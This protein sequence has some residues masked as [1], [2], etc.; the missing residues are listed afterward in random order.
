MKL[1]LRHKITGMACI[2]ALLPT[3]ALLLLAGIQRSGISSAVREDLDSV[4]Q[5]SIKQLTLD[6]YHSC[7]A[8][9]DF[10]R[11]E[12][13][14]NLN[15]AEKLLKAAGLVRLSAEKTE[16]HA[17]NQ[18]TE[19]VSTV[20]LP[21]MTLG[22]APLVQNAGAAVSVPVVDEV[23]GLV[24]GA[25]TIF[26]KMNEQ[27]DMLRI[28]TT[29]RTTGGTRATGTYIPA[30]HADGTP[31]PVISAIS[32]GE[33]FL[34]R[35]LVVHDWY[36]SAYKPIVNAERNPIGMLFVGIDQSRIAGL[37]SAITSVRAGKSGEVYVIR[38][39]NELRGRVIIPKEG[40]RE[41]DSLWETRDAEGKLFV[42]SIVTKALALAK[43]DVA[44]E[45]YLW[46]RDSNSAPKVVTAA[47]AYFQP[48][49]WIIIADAYEEEFHGARDKLESALG[50]LFWW[51]V[52]SGL[53]TMGIALIIAS[54]L[55]GKVTVP[56]G[57][58][59]SVAQ[60]IAQGDLRSARQSLFET[61]AAGDGNLPA[62]ADG[63]A[64][65]QDE[66]GQLIGAIQTMTGGLIS[67]VGQVKQSSIQLVSTSTEIA[68]AARQQEAT[69]SDL[70][71]STN[72]VV[73]ATRE[74]SATSQELLKTMNDVTQMAGATAS[75]AGS[76][77]SGLAGM[78]AN[79]RQLVDATRSIS[80]R[81]AVISDK[82]NNIN[83][84][85][86][87]IAKVA[88]ETNLL[89]LNAAIE[90]EKAGEYGL[91]FSVVA[92]EIRRLADQTA[93]ATLDIEQI[94]KEMRSAVSAGVM[95]MDKFTEE[96]RRNVAGVGK[97]SEQL[98]TIIGQ[99]QALTPRFESVNHGMQ[100][101][102]QGAEQI[103]GAM[104]SLSE[105]ARQTADSLKEFNKATEQLNEAAR[106][107]RNEVS[108]F[109]V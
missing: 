43:D 46:K 65:S 103:S 68:A 77:R 14:H 30:V 88:D 73:A 90:A 22:G 56:I 1:M 76:G 48:W 93:V 89:S 60:S 11:Q 101:Q 85:V 91:G 72:E 29:I 69:A 33:T 105:A 104:V 84:V 8:A 102:A 106:G 10:I 66:T 4:A 20:S 98:E 15:V 31:D 70:G 61:P 97:I 55:T 83:S 36:I 6:A 100:V 44:F 57:Q 42:Q 67:L 32:R 45:R 58:I 13:V 37:R 17:V 41:G 87:A 5:S 79:M 16:W 2:A 12:L 40:N 74:I 52:V 78:E 23:Q 64:P 26:Q 47:I 24:G 109:D 59:T 95:E 51:S 49:D 71:A 3:A 62:K 35:A 7:E 82:A 80:S 107:L 19:T 54:L 108:R 21:R 81:L 38:G 9:N 18:F 50:T 96:V 63:N 53:G 94:V 75:L 28:A 25:C 27:G 39:K 34:G 99:V 92:R 86:T